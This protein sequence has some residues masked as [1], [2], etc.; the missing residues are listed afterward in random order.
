[1]NISL[2]GE[3]VSLPQSCSITDLLTQHGYADMLVAV[4]INQ[5]FI[6]QSK[7]AETLVKDEDEI[8]VVAPMQGG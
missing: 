7:H 5:R 4:A 8:D 1:M 3:S 2:N 6:P